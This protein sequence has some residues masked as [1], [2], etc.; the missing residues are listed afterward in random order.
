MMAGA[1]APQYPHVQ[2]QYVAAKPLPVPQQQ[3]AGGG[4]GT[5]ADLARRRIFVRNLAWKT[6]TEGLRST[7]SRYGDVKECVVLAD[8]TTGKSK[9]YGF[10][11]Y[12][13]AG[14]AAR[15]LQNPTKM[16]DGRSATLHLA[17]LGKPSKSGGSS[18]M[19]DDRA[20]VASTSTTT[21]TGGG[22][23]CSD[24]DAKYFAPSTPSP[25]AQWQGGLSLPGPASATSWP[26]QQ[27]SYE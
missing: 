27:H 18:A 15:A 24:E 23:V 5:H 19:S 6:T 9:G 11:T 7:L 2:E 3:P 17:A 14:S 12:R 13:H 20:S 21:T 25:W 16:I 22:S 10:V 26:V 8:R 1:A 4:G